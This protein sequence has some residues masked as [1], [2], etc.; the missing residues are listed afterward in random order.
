MMRVMAMAMAMAT[1][2]AMAIEINNMSKFLVSDV[3]AYKEI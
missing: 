2:M 1:V 3:I